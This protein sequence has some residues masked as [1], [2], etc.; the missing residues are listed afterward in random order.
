MSPF[1]EDSVMNG[2]SGATEQEHESD[3]TSSPSPDHQG[4]S[5]AADDTS[6]N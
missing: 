2:Q 5:T 1:E 4:E 3:L 6:R